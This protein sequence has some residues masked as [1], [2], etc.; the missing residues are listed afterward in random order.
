MR[1][2]TFTWRI[3]P[4]IVSLSFPT[5][6]TRRRQGMPATFVLGQPEFGTSSGGTL[7]SPADVAIDS[8]GRIYVS[9]SGNNRVLIFESLVF[10]PLAGA[11]A[12]GVVGQQTTTG[13][14]PNWNSPDGLA[15]AGV[16]INRS[17]CSSIVRTHSM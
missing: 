14:T 16:C 12:S 6:R 11:T 1:P 3:Q 9:D 17:G 5:P 7:K 15:T 13:T 2:R 10:L 8:L 4:Q